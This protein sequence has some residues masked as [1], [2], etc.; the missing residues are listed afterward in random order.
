MA[1][2][3]L[4]E[5]KKRQQEQ[6]PAEQPQQETG[7][8][9]VSTNTQQQLNNYNQ[10]YKPSEAVQTAQQN[11]QTVQQ[12]KPQS[13]TSK[14]GAQLDNILAQIQG[15]QPFKYEFN[16]DGLFKSYADLFT[17]Q[18]KQA[19]QNAMGQ[20]AALTGGYGNS[21]A[22]AAGNQAY[23]QAILPLYDRGME[24]AQMARANYD[25]DRGDLYNQLGAL[26]GMD[27]SEYG[28][29]RD[30]VSD[31]RQDEQNAMDMYR[32]ERDF[33]YQDYANM[34]DYWNNQARAENADYRADQDEDYRRENMIQNQQQFETTTKMEYDQLAEKV[35]EFDASMSEDQRQYNAK[36]AASWVSDILANG[37]IPSM[38]LLAMAGLSYEDAQKLVAQV[39]AAGGGAG[40]KDK[41]LTADKLAQAVTVGTPAAINM[42]A[43]GM[44]LMADYETMAKAAADE[45][46][47]YDKGTQ[48]YEAANYYSDLYKNMSRNK[49]EL[50]ASAPEPS[51]TQKSTGVKMKWDSKQK[52]FVP[53]S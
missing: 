5:L 18:A 43:T 20:A 15:T 42:P 30:T 46:A 19:S 45:M 10:G 36:M 48:E 51:P 50:L 8:R 39:Q 4:E 44:P 52:K 23:Q 12:Q 34:L 27:E 26:Q 49:D 41:K 22:Q 28:R 35:R 47:K 11:M 32:D 33:G 24:L 37:Q 1:M 17:Q 31:W 53:V 13:F 40:G 7:L 6:A 9:G 29:Y 16:S 21:Y 2:S 14:Y 38:E 3:Y 25:K